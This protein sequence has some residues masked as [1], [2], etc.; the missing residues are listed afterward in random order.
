M[1][2]NLTYKLNPIEHLATNHPCYSEAAHFKISRLHLPVARLCNIQCN[3]CHRKV[4]QYYHTSRPGLTSEILKPK[5]ALKH[6]LDLLVKDP[7]LTVVGIAGPGEP[8][9]N[10]ETFETLELLQKHAPE[11]QLCI[12]TNG[13]LLSSKLDQLVNTGVTSITVT[14]NAVDP[15]IASKIYSHITFSGKQSRGLDAVKTLVRSQLDGIAKA[16]ERGFLVK[17]NTVLIPEVNL[18]H[19]IEI[20]DTVA[21]LKAYIMNI[22]PLIPLGK[23]ADMTPPTCDQLKIARAIAETKI[24]Q[25]RAC[26]QCRADACGIPGYE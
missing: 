1:D 3:F 21:N 4:S 17:I 2:Q 16:V 10:P 5:A 18:D 15:K 13:L 24:P 8:L 19:I 26:R 23:F 22:M 25:F 6:T 20:A 11:V 14:L 12:C 7:Q 9:Y